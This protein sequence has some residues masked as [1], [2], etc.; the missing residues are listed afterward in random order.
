MALACLAGGTAMAQSFTRPRG[1]VCDVPQWSVEQRVLYLTGGTSG[2]GTSTTHAGGQG[3]AG[4][5][6][7]AAEL[8]DLIAAVNA[9]SDYYVCRLRLPMG[10]NQVGP[11]GTSA[12]FWYNFGNRDGGGRGHFALRPGQPGF[13]AI[14]LNAAAA[15]TVDGDAEHT[16]AHEAWHTVQ[17]EIFGNRYS[18]H[19]V[20]EGQ[21][22]GMALWA[23]ESAGRLDHRAKLRRLARGSG[24]DVRWFIRMAGA[25]LYDRTL[26]ID[27]DPGRYPNSAAEMHHPVYREPE[28]AYHFLDHADGDPN[29]TASWPQPVFRRGLAWRGGYY[30][31]SF[32]HFLARERGGDL[33]INSIMQMPVPG[34]AEGDWVTWL[35]RGL[36][37]GGWPGGLAEAYG[38][39]IAEFADLPERYAQSR[40][41]QLAF[42]VWESLIWA[43]PCE[44]VILRPEYGES[45]AR[46][47]LEVD[48]LAARCI[49]VKVEGIGPP[50]APGANAALAGGVGPADLLVPIPPLI[51]VQATVVAGAAGRCGGA[52]Q[53][54]LGT[55]GRH[56]LSF[57]RPE[58]N[59]ADVQ[60][61]CDRRWNIAYAPLTLA[62]GAGRATMAGGLPQRGQMTDGWQ[63]VVLSNI[64]PTHPAATGRLEV[65]IFFSLQ[66]SSLAAEGTA[67][68]QPESTLSRPAPRRI[69]RAQPRQV[70]TATPPAPVRH[71]DPADAG[72]CGAAERALLTCGPFTRITLTGGALA[73]LLAATGMTSLG[74]A[75]GNHAMDFGAAQMD[76]VAPDPMDAIHI[77]NQVRAMEA[78]QAGALAA[79]ATRSA[80]EG[81]TVE[82]LVPRLPPG[83]TGVVEPA[84][85]QVSWSDGRQSGSLEGRGPLGI[86][87]HG[88]YPPRG[89]LEIT[90]NAP[91]A[92]LA[93]R[94]ETPLFEDRNPEGSA[95]AAQAMPPLTQVGRISG[96]FGTPPLHVR[97]ES[98]K[99]EL[100]E[101]FFRAWPRWW[102]T[103]PRPMRA[104]AAAAGWGTPPPAAPPPAPAA[105]SPG[106]NIIGG[107]SGGCN[108]SCA[109]RAATTPI[110]RFA[111]RPYCHEEW[112]SCHLEG[113]RRN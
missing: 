67:T 63:T 61:V 11:G 32:W 94:F 101:A 21:A 107:L 74:G 39:F 3:H 24:D 54:G 95:G 25:R 102:E 69:P 19:W 5:A 65:E 12:M 90:A 52:T 31:Q 9:A 49:H 68:P 86:Q 1:A 26:A 46:L 109:A 76:G 47:S 89:R 28:T 87:R 44:Q 53:L 111:C 56:L 97:D 110:L 83:F 92:G 29:G 41:G 91:G 45:T 40:R 50:P 81:V 16:V 35:D 93:G 108:C 103:M 27:M 51:G 8:Q 42:P 85:I 15:P 104:M 60:T 22:D 70:A 88:V 71:Q 33:A 38:H 96:S 112:A 113:I 7:T 99:A 58:G 84:A 30:T 100:D 17:A 78:F 20:L 36:R 62:G 75:M 18:P 72:T 57:P 13:P 55:R 34:N 66:F 82:I 2:I 106:S 105:A 43:K 80:P 4:R 10:T 37:G 6:L 59:R 48:P 14:A 23:L 98:D 77:G 79:A 73:D 64:H